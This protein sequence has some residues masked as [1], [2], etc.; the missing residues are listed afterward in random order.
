[1]KKARVKEGGLWGG[2]ETYHRAVRWVRG[3]RRRIHRPAESRS[4]RE[5]SPER[6]TRGANPAREVS[7]G[8][9]LN[10]HPTARV[11]SERKMASS[12]SGERLDNSGGFM[13]EDTDDGDFDPNNPSQSTP[14]GDD[15]NMGPYGPALERERGRNA[16][17][18]SSAGDGAPLERIV[19]R[20]F[21]HNDYLMV[22]DGLNRNPNW[23][24]YPAQLASVLKACTQLAEDEDEAEKRYARAPP[25]TPRF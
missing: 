1:M 9:D 14:G 24:V 18:T 25:S 19:S 21:P 13:S 2:G 5:T 8:A 3:T 6:Q 15:G 16:S 7:G 17:P 20:D 23:T 4:I 12:S 11:A 22:A 10:V